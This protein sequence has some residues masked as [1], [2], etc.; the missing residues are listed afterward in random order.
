MISNEFV[1]LEGSALLPLSSRAD[2][3][4]GK[5]KDDMGDEEEDLYDELAADAA[6]SAASSWPSKRYAYV[7][8]G[9]DNTLKAQM[10]KEGTTFNKWIDGVMT[11][12]QTYYRHRS[13]PTKIEFKVSNCGK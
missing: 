11:H 2:D 4:Y 5:H 7:K 3:A 10:D 6:A 1:L 13:L 8:F 12:V 9:Y